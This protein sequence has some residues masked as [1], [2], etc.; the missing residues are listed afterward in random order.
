MRYKFFFWIILLTLFLTACGQTTSAT[1]TDN[2]PSASSSDAQPDTQ[3]NSPFIPYGKNVRFEQISLEEGLSQ[4]VVTAI[5]QDRQGFLWVGTDDG[6]NRYDGYTFKIYKPDSNN[7][8]SISDRS[9]TSIVEDNQGYLWIGTRQGGL[10]RYDPVTGKFTHYFKDRINPESIVSN[11]IFDLA[12]DK[13]G[14]WIGTNNGLDFLHFGTNTFTHYNDSANSPVRLGSNFITTLLK[15]SNGVLWIGTVSGGVSLYDQENNT[16][17]NYQNNKNKSTSLSHNR[18]ISLA[19][20]KDGEI[21]IGTGNGL[22]RFIPEQNYFTRYLTSENASNNFTGNIIYSV[23]VDQIGTVWIGTNN[24]LSR[25]DTKTKKFYYY[26][27]DPTVQN[28]LSNNGIYKIYEDASGVLWI[29]TFGG[30][31]NKYNRQ[32]DRFAYYRNMPDNIN[33]LSSD[34]IFAILADTNG[35][36]WIGTLDGGLNRFDPKTERF[37]RYQYNEK[38]PSSLSSNNIISLYTDR[39]GTLWIGT[40]N[41]LNRF[42]PLTNSFTHYQPPPSAADETTRFAVFAMHEDTNGVFWIGSN[43]GLLLFDRNTNVF[44]KYI[45]SNND[46]LSRNKINV[47]FEDQEKNLWIGTSDDGLKRINLESEEITSYRFNPEDTSA[48]GSNVVLCVYQQKNGALWVGTHGG[49]LSL[50]N[51]ETDSFTHFTENE[52]LPN[53][54]IYGILEDEKGNLWLSTNFGLSRFNPASQTFRNFTASDGLQSNEF[55]QN[56]YAK[57]IDGTMYF[58]GINGINIFEPREITD[59]PFSPN[60]ALTSFTLSGA[61]FVEENKTTEYL[62]TITLTWPQ[63]SFEFEFAAFAYEQPSQNQYS[64]MLDGFDEDWINTGN[65]RNGRYTN[66]PGGTYTLHLRGTNSDGVWSDK[67]QSVQIVVVPPYWETW[68]F[69]GLLVIFFGFVIVGG[70]RWRV[71]NIENKNQELERLVKKRTGDL[72]KRTVEIEALYQADEKILRSVT[73]NQ[74]F[75]ALVDV[76]V[77]LLNADRSV[78]FAWNESQRKIMPRVSRGFQPETLTAFKFDRD[79]GMIGIAMKTSAAFI[80]SDLKSNTLRE[81]VQA[82]LQKEGIESFA[83]FPIVVDGKV[84]AIFNVAYTNAHALTRDSIRLFTALVNRAS[85]SIANM[86]LFEQT[87]DLAVMEERNRL[88][89]DLHDSAKQKAF[90]ALA[91]LGT[92]NGMVKTVPQ[93]FSPHLGEA[94]TLIYEVIQELNFLIQ[95]IYPIALQE[96]GL[97]TTLREYIF[98]WENRNDAVV[99]LKIQHGRELPLDTEQA[100]YRVIQ[101]ALA[102]ISRHSKAKRADVSLI[103]NPDILQVMI[104]DDGCG[105]DMHQRA[106]GMGFRSMRERINSIRGTLQVQSAPQQGTRLIIQI[107]LKDNSGD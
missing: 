16:L 70:L 45:T 9:I 13:D 94:E 11:Q 107:P 86:D 77:S 103:Y 98:E 34:F 64:Y 31:L 58:G 7:P 97:E 47:I 57:G 84:V 5:L 82:A 10:N 29:G 1:D 6:L 25:Y 53:N 102:N 49:G 93:E 46:S 41:A 59:N 32:Q 2:S 15:A 62:K 22:N 21:W 27:H 35:Y 60:I 87:K 43:R 66:L 30:G 33:S 100:V 101:E 85:L 72:E 91:Q 14:L 19:E 99:N 90:A 51:P 40:G 83:H 79:E 67:I 3:L 69:R 8:Y 106:K 26:Q 76:S 89:R 95:E 48:L 50:Y 80:V 104:A 36:I 105:F 56:A 75:Q 96:K 17:T 12:V 65:Q 23:F 61:P 71:K 78:V 74:I 52:G 63:D 4:S 42:D 20:G 55:N 54:V 28:S 73:L 37:I 88:A 39:Q 68:W 24:G 44:T 81:D 38:D 92:V 18:V